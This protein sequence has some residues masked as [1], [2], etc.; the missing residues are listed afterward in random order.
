[1]E[2]REPTQ[3][4]YRWNKVLDPSLKEGPWTP[5]ED[6]VGGPQQDASRHSLTGCSR[7][8]GY[9]DLIAAVD[10]SATTA[11]LTDG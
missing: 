4:V 2:S 7:L 6:Q 8:H 5:E 9:L 11:V 10:T 3:L 1:M